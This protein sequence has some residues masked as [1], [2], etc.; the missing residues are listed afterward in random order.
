M[1]T[2]QEQV[3][4][5]RASEIKRSPRWDDA[6]EAKAFPRPKQNVLIRVSGTGILGGVTVY[7]GSAVAALVKVYDVDD[8]V[9]APDEARDLKAIVADASWLNT[10]FRPRRMRK[11]IAFTV[12]TDLLNGLVLITFR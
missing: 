9:T 8:L 4:D 3:A 6:W 10:T 12:T 5:I 7:M 1:S 11:G 2:V